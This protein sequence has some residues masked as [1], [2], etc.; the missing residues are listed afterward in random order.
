[1]SAK[2]CGRSWLHKVRTLLKTP[3]LHSPFY[4]PDAVCANRPKICFQNNNWV[5]D[6]CIEAIVPGKTWGN[7]HVLSAVFRWISFWTSTG[8]FLHVEHLFLFLISMMN[9]LNV[10]FA[11]YEPE[12]N[13][14]MTIEHASLI[15]GKKSYQIK[16][17]MCFFFFSFFSK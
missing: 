1:M 8:I 5:F 17:M 13:T 2:R 7:L 6:N 9:S 15:C 11:Y 4:K 10:F 14:N 12:M 16:V 3:A